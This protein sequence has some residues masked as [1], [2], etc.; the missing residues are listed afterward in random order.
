MEKHQGMTKLDGIY[1]D[2][3]DISLFS[4]KYFKHMK[5]KSLAKSYD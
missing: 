2:V 3:C 5:V 1:S 4:T